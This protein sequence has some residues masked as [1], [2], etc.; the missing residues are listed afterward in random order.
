MLESAALLPGNV[1]RAKPYAAQM[2][3]NRLMTTLGMA[4]IRLFF[5]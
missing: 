1:K 3:K 2:A 4:I 5:M